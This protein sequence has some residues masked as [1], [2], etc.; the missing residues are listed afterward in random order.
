MMNIAVDTSALVVIARK[1]HMAAECLDMLVNCMSAVISTGTVA[2]CLIVAARRGISR[3]VEA[4]I[5][6]FDFEIAPVTAQGARAVGAA[7]ARWGKGIHPAGLNFGDCFAYA[8]AMER[9]C[10]LLYIGDDF[11]RTDIRSALD[12]RP[13]TDR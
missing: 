1:E 5:E 11:K 3:D 6:Q 13:A 2:E 9:G 12:G 8:L 10:P 7:Y 4:L